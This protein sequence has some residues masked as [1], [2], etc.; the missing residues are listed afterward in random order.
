[1]EQ[2]EVIALEVELKTQKDFFQAALIVS[3]LMLHVLH[4]V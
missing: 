3:S 2:E 4:L 1:M